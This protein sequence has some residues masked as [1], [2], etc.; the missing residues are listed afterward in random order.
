MNGVLILGH[1]FSLAWLLYAV[2]AD[3]PHLYQ[4]LLPAAAAVGCLALLKLAPAARVR[5]ALAL[6]GLFAG[7]Y[8]AEIALGV[9]DPE[10]ARQ[11]AIR[12]VARDKGV[13]FDARTRLQV[14]T[15]L[16]KHDVRAYPTF[17]PFHLLD[18]PLSVEGVKILPVGGVARAVAVSCNES[19]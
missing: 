6:A 12:K 17:Y 13:P 11:Q 14:I 5:A 2:L 4:K 3:K 8:A 7:L 18:S 15:D 1:L 9:L 10:R 19:G 16:R